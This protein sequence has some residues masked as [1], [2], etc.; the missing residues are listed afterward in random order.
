MNQFRRNV[1]PG[2]FYLGEDGA[3]PT[4]AYRGNGDISLATITQNALDTVL[5][6]M[7]ISNQYQAFDTPFL[8][9]TGKTLQLIIYFGLAMAAYPAFFALY[10]TLERLRNV[11]QLHYSNGVRSICLWSAYLSFDFMIV[12]AASILATI[13]FRGVSDAWYHPEYLFVVFFCYGIA[14][15]LLS[16]VVSLFSQSQL[17]SFAFAAGGQAVMFLLYF[18]AYLSVVTYAPPT[19]IDDYLLVTHF[20]IGLIT[21]SGNLV[22]ALFVA[23]N[24]FSTLCEGKTTVPSYPGRITLYGG[25]ILYLIG[26][27]FFLFGILLWWDS[28]SVWAKI[29]RKQYRS[30]DDEEADPLDDEIAA[31][32]KRISASPDDGLRVQHIS[33]AYG[34]NLAVQDVTFGVKRGEVFALLGPNGAGKSTTI[35]LI[36]GDILPSHNSG[37]IY[38]E[39]VALSKNRAAARNHLGVCPQVD[40][41]DQMTVLEH[42]RFYARVRGVEDVEMNVQEIINAVGLG[43]FQHRMAAKLSG[44]NKRKLSLGIAL[45]GN[46]SVLLLDEPSSGMDVCAKRVMWKTLASVV[47]GRSLVLTTHSME[48]ADALADRAGIMGKKMLALGTS[49]GLRKKHGDRYHVHVIMRTAPHTSD[50]DMNRTKDWIS[51]HL[52]GAEVEPRTFHGQLRF[53]VPASR[54]VVQEFKSP[55]GETDMVQSSNEKGPNRS[56]VGALFTLLETHKEELG[57]EFYSVSQTTLDQVFLSIVGK[58]NIEEENYGQVVKKRPIWK[59]IIGG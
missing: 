11:R 31:E 46:P 41:C 32:I 37:D 52:E 14:S 9:S 35:S 33:K 58:H 45:T 38:V 30:E 43:P 50:E 5:L 4:F 20:T 12:L 56:G 13:I 48:E 3:P 18:I 51:R 21:P 44:G 42:L 54:S 23:L 39:D 29:R 49:E 34:S 10:P 19:K 26:Q 36:R 47:P 1:T 22:R 53:S 27:S 57:F 15:T 17:A 59:Q 40:A 8:P 25:P 24:V 2:G 6:N 7:S 28:G 16:Y 55:D